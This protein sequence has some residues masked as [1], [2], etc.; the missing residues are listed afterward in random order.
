MATRS[1]ILAWGS[2]AGYGP[3]GRTESDT[4]ERLTHT[5]THTRSTWYCVIQLFFRIAIMALL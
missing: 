1:S 3:W 2:L 5:H 4:P